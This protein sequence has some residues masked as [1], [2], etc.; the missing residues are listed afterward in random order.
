MWRIINH[1]HLGWFPCDMTTI[2]YS[3]NSL[4]W[5]YWLGRALITFHS[6]IVQTV[7]LRVTLRVLTCTRREWSREWFYTPVIFQLLN[8]ALV[9]YESHA[10][11]GGC[12]GPM[13]KAEVDNT[14]RDL[15][16]SSYL[17]TAASNNCCII[18]SKYFH[19]SENTKISW[20]WFSLRRT[21]VA[22]QWQIPPLLLH[23]GC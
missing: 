4:F 12:Y 22:K 20:N 5:V 23:F 13:P 18:Y 3:R 16:N 1:E 7:C 8:Q 17:K 19:G 2:I 11:R 9:W 6:C 10:D 15:H 21:F 14:L